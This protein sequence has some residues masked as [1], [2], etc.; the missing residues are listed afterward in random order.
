MPGGGEVSGTA[1]GYYSGITDFGF[2]IA[3]ASKLWIFGDA[4]HYPER[5]TQEPGFVPLELTECFHSK[6]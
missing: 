2:M 1:A 5:G 6:S 3:A 4:D